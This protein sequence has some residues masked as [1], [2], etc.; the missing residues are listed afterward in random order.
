MLAVTSNLA[1][2]DELI[3]P[4]SVAPDFMVRLRA[5]ETREWREGDYRV[6]HLKGNVSIEQGSTFATAQEGIL[7]IDELVETAQQPNQIIGYLE[8]NVAVN[9]SFGGARAIWTGK[10]KSAFQGKSWLGRF[11]TTHPVEFSATPTKVEKDADL[12]IRIR[13]LTARGNEGGSKFQLVQYETQDGQPINQGDLLLLQPPVQPQPPFGA[14]VNPLPAPGSAP[15]AIPLPNAPG[16][17]TPAAGPMPQT[18]ID[19]GGRN[20]GRPTIRSFVDPDFNE[21]VWVF[22]QGIKIS[23]QSDELN[24]AAAAVGGVDRIVIKADRAV[25]WTNTISSITSNDANMGKRWEFYLEGNIEFASGDRVIYAERMYYDVNFK[26]GT[27]LDAE[28]L[29]PVPEYDGLLRMK[30]EILQQI[31]ERTFRAYGGALT[32]SRMGVPRYWVQSNDLTITHDQSAKIDPFTGQQ[33]IDPVTGTP[34]L[35]HEY[36]AQSRNNFVYVGGVPVFY[37]PSLTTDLADPSYY[38]RKIAIKNDSVFGSQVLTDWDMYQ[39]LGVRDKPD[40]TDWNLAA[41]Y[42]SERGFGLGTTFRYE[43]EDLFGIQGPYSGRID[44]WGINDNGLDNLGQDRRAVPLEKDLRGRALLNHRHRF[45]SGWQITGEIGYVSDRN[46]LEQYFEHEWD[47]QKDQSTGLEILRNFGNQTIAISADVRLNEFFTQ[48]EQLPR[49]DHYILGQ[50]VF[51]TGLVWN[52][53]SHGGYYRMKPADA[54]VNPVDLAKFDPLAWEADVEGA[55]AGTR[56]ELEY[57]FQVGALKVTPYALGDATYYGEDLFGNDLT[58]L[59]GQGGVRLSLPF[60]KVDPSVQSTLLN[61]NGL[62]HKV[63]LDADLFY[64]DANTDLATLPLYDA[65]DD[66]AQ[67]AFRRRFFFDTFAGVPGGNTPLQYDERFFA[68]RSGMQNYVTGSSSEIAD[69]MTVAKLGLRQRWQTKRGY[70]GQERIVDWIELDLEGSVFPNA[71]RDNFGADVGLL[72]Y[73][74]RWHVGDRFTLLSDGYADVYGD[75]LRT[76]S[77]GGL[78]SR[79]EVGNFYLGFRSIEGPITSSIIT[80]SVAYRMSDKWIGNAGA[81]YDLG[82]TG[83]IGQTLSFTRIGESFLLRFGIKSDSSRGNVGAVF[84]IEPRFMGRSK[85]G[86]L[87]GVDLPPPGARGL[88]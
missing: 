6:I 67:E 81:S 7:W 49:I 77:V 55:R 51:G 8:G 73:G 53:H 78:M 63:T 25:G 61:V 52:A 34:L 29:T 85:L 86:R 40:G 22:D 88:E 27:I 74:F 66:D 64:A 12:P 23:I 58:R 24:Q 56:Q 20:G 21:Q 18:K 45:D 70:P 13:G 50:S 87:G 33:A 15:G 42:M 84:A 83:N 59:Y 60:W 11:Q 2:A 30:A 37:W 62:A 5:D 76:V 35:R 54:P 80:A 9:F 1:S 57:P 47:Q 32:S 41:D 10:E 36:L 14:G 39:L 16:I 46:F 26:R 43:R 65:L 3:S 82:P 72:N 38:L 69:D 4:P 44:M 68:L 17:M 31:D 75:G 71:D 48:T 19:F 79:P 28:V